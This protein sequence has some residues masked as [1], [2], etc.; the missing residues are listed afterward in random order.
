MTLAETAERCPRSFCNPSSKDIFSA[1][2]KFLEISRIFDVNLELKNAEKWTF[3]F[4]YPSS[5]MAK[6]GQ[7]IREDDVEVKRAKWP[8]NREVFRGQNRGRWVAA[9]CRTVIKRH[10]VAKW[11]IIKSIIKVITLSLTRLECNSVFCQCITAI[12]IIITI[13]YILSGNPFYCPF[14]RKVS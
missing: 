10:R 12:I 2:L 11:S 14:H 4:P 1:Y 9:Q 6:W 8:R 7:H 5:M 13:Y 3:L